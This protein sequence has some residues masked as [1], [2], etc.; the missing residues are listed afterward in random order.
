ME[1]PNRVRGVCWSFLNDNCTFGERCRYRHE[2]TPI[3]RHF[4]KGGCWFGDNCKFLHVLPSRGILPEPSVSTSAASGR[5]DRGGRIA[6]VGMFQQQSSGLNSTLNQT[7]GRVDTRGVH[8][9]DSSTETQFTTSTLGSEIG[10]LQA[11]ARNGELEGATAAPQSAEM[12][13][14]I[15][16][17]KDVTCGICMEKIFEKHDLGNRK[18]GIL[19]NCTHSFCL[20]CIRKWRKTRDISPVVVKSCP[21]CRVNSGFFVPHDYWVEGR[22]KEILIDTFKKKFSNKTC[23]FFLRHG[24]CPFKSDCLY[25]HDRTLHRLSPEI[26]EDTLALT[27]DVLNFLIAMALTD[28]DEDDDDDDDDDDGDDDEDD[29]GFNLIN[30]LS[31]LGFF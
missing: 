8:S 30:A 25:Q 1:R 21:V 16:C 29:E 19:P 26:P 9:Q 27:S 5:S 2:R 6:T 14:A 22:E 7:T 15:H 31:S 17:S 24:R 10:H 28:S 13:Q 18:F 23:G 12:A 11:N 3:C 4:Q 20:D